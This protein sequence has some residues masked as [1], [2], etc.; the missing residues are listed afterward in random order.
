VT[1]KSR[2]K[3]S[4]LSMVEAEAL[5]EALA[6]WRYTMLALGYVTSPWEVAETHRKVV[7]DGERQEA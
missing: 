2:E 5:S 3:P 4:S 6:S 7:F 1:S